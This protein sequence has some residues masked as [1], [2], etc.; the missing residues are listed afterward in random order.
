MRRAPGRRRGRRGRAEAGARRPAAARPPGPTT[1]WSASRRRAGRRTSWRQLGVARA[2]RGGHGRRGQQPGQPHRRA[3]PTSPSRCSTGPEVLAGSTRMKAGTAQ[4]VVLNV[5]STAAM[6]RTG[7]ST[8]R[9]WSTCGP[10]TTS[11]G[12]A[13]SASLREA[14][15]VSDTAAREALE[16]ADGATEDRARRAPHGGGRRV[17]CSGAGRRGRPGPRRGTAAGR[18]GLMRIVAVA[19]GT[20]ADAL[21]IGVVDVGLEG[22]SVTMGIVGTGQE[23]WPDDLRQGLLDLLPP[24]AT[25]AGAIC[26][27]DQ[28]IGVAVAEAVGRVVSQLD[29]PPHLVVS[30]GQTVFHDVR[31]GRCYGTLQLGQP[32]WV[33]ERTGLPV[34][35]D[36]RARDVAAGGHGAPL[37]S[38]LDGLWL[39]GPRRTARGAQPRR[40]R[41]RLG[42]RRRGSGREGAGTPGPA[43]CLLDVAAHRVTDGRLNHDVDGHLARQGAVRVD[44]LALLLEHPHFS[45]LP[46]RLDRARGLLGRLPRRRPRPRA[47]DLGARPARDAHGADRAHRHARHRAV[48][49][50]GGR[51]LRRGSAQPGADGGAPAKHRTCPARHQR[52][53]RASRPTGRRS[54][55]GRCSGFLTWHGLAG[56]TT[57]TGAREARVLGRITPGLEPLRLPKPAAWPPRRLR[58]LAPGD[59]GQYSGEGVS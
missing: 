35:S 26:Q 13:Q 29:R 31:D 41:Q 28:L 42:G 39:A 10:R 19:S 24:A 33:A 43:N 23:P 17:G 55:C 34:V 47:R 6:V 45:E 27:L 16:A 1:S 48:R 20:S 9:G 53:A 32:A 8:A 51:R 4:K 36:L 25:T 56:T 40:H 3:A 12:C 44:L 52:R 21:D 30:P 59:P 37:A 22:S 46:A 57:A 14:T 58:V 7:R 38:T 5:L 54:C 15:G 50:D 11:C 49:R 18:S 2:S